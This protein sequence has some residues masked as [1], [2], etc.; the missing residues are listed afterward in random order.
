MSLHYEEGLSGMKV[1]LHRDIT[2]ANSPVSHR[3]DMISIGIAV[4]AQVR[5]DACQQEREDID[6]I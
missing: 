1:L 5:A 6:L 3:I 2:I 4:M